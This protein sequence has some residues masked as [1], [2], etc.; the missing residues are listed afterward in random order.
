MKTGFVSFE[1]SPGKQA[2]EK[3]G[4]SYHLQLSA[5]ICRSLLRGRRELSSLGEPNISQFEILSDLLVNH[6]G[7]FVGN[8]GPFCGRT[9][10]IR[11]GHVVF[12]PAQTCPPPPFQGETLTVSATLCTFG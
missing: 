4:I 9:A 7:L 12:L 5:P 2:A 11:D 1:R 10:S 3:T 8:N 6:G